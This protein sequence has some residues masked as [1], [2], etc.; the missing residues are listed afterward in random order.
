[1][2]H[3]FWKFLFDLQAVPDYVT[4]LKVFKTIC[5]PQ[6]NHFGQTTDICKTLFVEIRKQNSNLALSK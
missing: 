2:W 6:L 5:Q 3:D 1:L 4:D